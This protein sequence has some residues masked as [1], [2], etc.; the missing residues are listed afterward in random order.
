MKK[1]AV[2]ALGIIGGAVGLIIL[3]YLLVF[4]TAW[5]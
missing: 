4:I 5:L 1:T 2:I 3:F